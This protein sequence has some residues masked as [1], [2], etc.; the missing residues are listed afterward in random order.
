MMIVTNIV[1]C[2][3]ITKENNSMGMEQY[4]EYDEKI[5]IEYNGTIVKGFLK[6]YLIEENK[7]I[8]V[9]ELQDGGILKINPIEI[10][11]IECI[12]HF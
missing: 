1:P 7:E 5:K 9:L 6:N 8:I 2:I 3:K 12:S 11:D 4:I 10:E